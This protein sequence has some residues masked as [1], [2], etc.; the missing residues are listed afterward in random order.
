MQLVILAAGHGTRFGGLKQLAPI[1]PDG[2]AVMD[3]TALAALEC[4]FSSVV[5]V[6]RDEIRDEIAE[7]VRQSWSS[8]LP[9]VFVC[10]RG[11]AG[12]AQAVLSAREVLE[13]G[14]AVANADDLY[15]APALAGLLSQF[16]HTE[17]RDTAPHLLV[18]YR[19][20][21]TVLTDAPVTRGLCQIASDGSLDAIVE[22][23]VELRPDGRFDAR[24]LAQPDAP[25]RVL[26][27]QELVSM[28][29]WGFQLRILDQLEAAVAAFQPTAGGR[30]EL[31]LPDVMNRVVSSRDD[32]VEVIETN[33]RCIGL[34]H[35]EDASILREELLARPLSEELLR[36]TPGA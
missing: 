10:Q 6:V 2:E 27:G 9:V 32:G 25:S 31:I 23:V 36:A 26:S 20:V 16:S 4:G 33:E 15:S 28:N 11:G 3:Y 19:L 1:G 8:E 13:G 14:F 22:Q 17:Q 7:H 24:P 34:T 21:R 29:L 5:L 35:Q 30:K 12:T 18:G